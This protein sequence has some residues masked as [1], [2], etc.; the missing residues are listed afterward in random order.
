[1]QMY[2]QIRS[3]LLSKKNE[4]VNNF[5]LFLFS[6][7][8]ELVVGMLVVITITHRVNYNLRHYT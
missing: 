6:A 3:E 2:V 1:M 8:D 7:S 5:L 4:F